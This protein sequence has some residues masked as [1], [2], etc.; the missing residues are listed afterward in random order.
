MKPLAISPLAAWLVCLFVAS[1][2]YNWLVSAVNSRYPDHGYV[3][4]EVAA[5]VA[6]VILSAGAFGVLPWE[7]V[8]VLV[9]GFAAAGTMMVLGSM[10]RSLRS[11]YRVVEAMRREIRDVTRGD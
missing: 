8:G 9:V 7:A 1:V 4:F 2:G 10:Y 6:G 3:A 5:G 11:R